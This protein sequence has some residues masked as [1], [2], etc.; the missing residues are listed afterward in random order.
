MKSG[1]ILIVVASL[2]MQLGGANVTYVH[3][4]EINAYEHMR[5]FSCTFR[6]SE[7]DL[8]MTWSDHEPNPVRIKSRDS[9]HK[10]RLVVEGIE[11]KRLLQAHQ[12]E[13]ET[14]PVFS[15]SVDEINLSIRRLQVEEYSN[16]PFPQPPSFFRAANQLEMRAIEHKIEQNIIPC[17]KKSYRFVEK[18]SVLQ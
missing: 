5:S 9:N 11:A 6:A 10:I 1:K 7:R 2:M 18:E 17:L 15:I 13:V 3:A 4:A 12:I 14:V 8:F 16:L